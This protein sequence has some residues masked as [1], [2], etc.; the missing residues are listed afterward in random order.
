LPSANGG[1]GNGITKFSG[2]TTA[3]KTFILPDASA[4]ILTTNA[5]VTV[6]QGGTGLTTFGGANTVLY[7][8]AADAL[9]SVAASSA[10]GQFLQTTASGGAPSWKTILAVANGGTGSST[11]NFVDLTT[12]QTAAG[13][14][15]WS[16]LGTFNLGLTASGAAVSI[17]DNSNFATNINTGTSTGTVTVGGTGTQTI[18]IGNGAGIKTVNLGSSNTTSTTSIEAG[19]GGLNIGTAAFA[20]T[21]TIGNGTGATS[22]VLNAGT[23]AINVGTNAIARTITIGNA[24]GASTVNINTGTGGSTITT[25]N[26]IFALNTGTGNIGVGTDAAAKTITMGNGTGA[27]SLVLNA[28]TGPINIGTNGIAHTTTIG[29]TTGA[30]VVNINVGTGGSTYT[31]TNSTFALNTGTGAI[32]LGTDAVAKTIIIGNVTGATAVNINTGTGASTFATTGAGTLVLGGAASTGALTLGSSTA[33]QTINIGTGT[34]ANA[35]N[36]A[37]GGTGNVTIGNATGTVNL[38][39]LTASR[40]VKADGSKNLISATIDLA[41]SNDVTGILPIAN[42]GTGSSS[43]NFVDL[44]SVQTVAGVKTFSSL[45]VLSSLTAGSIPFAAAG[46]QI[47]QDNAKLF[48]DNTNKWLGIGTAVPTAPLDVVGDVHI[49]ATGS[50]RSDIGSPNPPREIGITNWADGNGA[51]F[52]FG[53]AWNALQN[54]Y[55]YRMQITSYHGMEI[56]GNRRDNSGLAFVVGAATDPALSVIGTTLAAPVLAVTAPNLQTGNLQEWKVNGTTLASV[57]SSGA[58]NLKAGT[59][60]AGGAPIKFTSGTNLTAA[61]AGAVEYDGTNFT[62]TNSTATRYTLAKTLTSTPNLDFANTASGSYS[63]VIVGL[64][65]TADGDVVVL[66]TLNASI[67]PGTTYTTWVSSA[68]NVTVRFANNSGAPIDPPSRSFRVSVLKY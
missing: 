42:G 37:T 20:K 66:G 6:A 56:V 29:N 2:P 7:T 52:T 59:A 25:A 24:T 64:T 53:D 61:E 14:K 15:T 45:P 33:A 30:S 36:V 40:P 65:G 48:W 58:I 39:K 44:T 27:T 43:Q 28:G 21:I 51:R 1:T 17:N 35:V 26:G 5:A 23:G 55:N 50:G 38:P 3:E 31:T 34:G 18:S 67:Y 11:Q 12:V 46:G 57:S 68:G 32:N 8:T 22:L 47:S 10:A 16:D 4:T 9:N 54:A 19:S 41:S 49:S 60:A 63:D 62:V 13:A